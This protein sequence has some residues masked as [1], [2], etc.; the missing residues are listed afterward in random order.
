MLQVSFQAQ[1]PTNEWEEH[2][3][4]PSLTWR[5]LFATLNPI[6]TYVIQKKDQGSSD[7]S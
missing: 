3:S 5:D 7:A 4:R 1:V 2:V 6:N